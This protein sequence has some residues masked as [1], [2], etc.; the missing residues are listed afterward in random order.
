[1]TMTNQTGAI[2]AAIDAAYGY[3]DQCAACLE[4]AR[5]R[6]DSL[7]LDVSARPLRFSQ[8]DPDWAM[9]LYADHCK[10]KM[11]EA[12]CYVTCLYS[13]MWWAGYPDS[14][15][16]F[17]DRLNEI[18]AF[19]GCEL[20][21][22]KWVQSIYPRLAWHEAPEGPGGITSRYDWPSDPADL[23][24]LDTCLEQNPTIV[25][26]DFKPQTK[27]IDRHFVL[28]YHYVPPL[29]DGSIEDDLLIMDP[30]TGTHTSALTY[31]NPAWM[32]DGSMPHG[33]TKVQ[34]VVTGVRFFHVVGER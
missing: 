18:E 31:F 22:P 6:I 21:H 2:T 7:D 12:G 13:L 19:A 23:E 27:A 30:W 25:Q 32:R 15:D 11:A 29:E 8:R 1:M 9:F 26:L 5:R 34:R 14:M 4:E 10:L 28:A 20:G 24:V 33:V 16:D 3:L 17:L